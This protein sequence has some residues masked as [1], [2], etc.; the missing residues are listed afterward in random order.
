MIVFHLF[1][2][3]WG[4]YRNDIVQKYMRRIGL[5][6]TANITCCGPVASLRPFQLRKG[7]TSSSSA[8][9]RAFACKGEF[10]QSITLTVI[11]STHLT[12]YAVSDRTMTEL[13]DQIAQDREELGRRPPGHSTGR[14]ETLADLAYFLGD[15]FEE[16]DD[17]V[18][19]DEAI[20]LASTG[21][22]LTPSRPSRPSLVTL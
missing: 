16:T 3:P 12:P 14:A 6:A 13:D 4:D 2:P 20:A 7:Q 9:Y 22:G 21:I 1:G 17:I 18:D 8:H 5:K 11:I 10:P 15:E 19:L